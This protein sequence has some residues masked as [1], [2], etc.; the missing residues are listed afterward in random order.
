M[1][2]MVLWGQLFG[3]S[4][5][6]V[7]LSE[8][9]EQPEDCGRALLRPAGWPG[10]CRPP[11]TLPKTQFKEEIIRVNGTQAGFSEKETKRILFF[12]AI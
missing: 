7:C 2:S 10:I 6:A 4:L 9:D 3:D 8:A 1:P 5:G 11:G 12:T